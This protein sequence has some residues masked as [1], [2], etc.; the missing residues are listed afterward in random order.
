VRRVSKHFGMVAH[1]GEMRFKKWLDQNP[2]ELLAQLGFKPG[3]VVLDFGCGSGKYTIP[4]ARLV[5]QKGRVY[6]LDVSDAALERVRAKAAKEGLT[7]IVI[8]RSTGEGKI[9]LEKETVDHVLLI[10]VLQEVEDRKGLL[11]EIH[12]VAKPAAVLTIFPM[13]LRPAEVEDLVTETGFILK[14][15]EFQDRILVFMRC[16]SHSTSKRS[17]EK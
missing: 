6:A 12:R 16:A 9:P 11:D 3:Q 5:T 17:D 7:N 2:N 4:A 8:I 10:D 15:R 13:H 14:G 1:L